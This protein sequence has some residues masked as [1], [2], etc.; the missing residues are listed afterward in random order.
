MLAKNLIDVRVR[1]RQR[2]GEKG[3]RRGE[4][5]LKM[6]RRKPKHNHVSLKK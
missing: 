2:K 3:V 5:G 4:G 1:E 6:Q